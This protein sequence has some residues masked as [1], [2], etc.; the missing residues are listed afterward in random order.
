MV[1]LKKGIF[2]IYWYCKD[3]KKLKLKKK[4]K[5]KS[6]FKHIPI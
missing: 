4:Y 3:I 2:W 6:I 5:Q 1:P